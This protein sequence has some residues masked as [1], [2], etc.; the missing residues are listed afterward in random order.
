[1]TQDSGEDTAKN[2]DRRA[3][4]LAIDAEVERQLRDHVRSAGALTNRAALLVTSALIFVSIPKEGDG[5]GCWYA[6][7]LICGVAAAILGVIAL[8]FR[9]KNQEV[10]LDSL[11]SQLVGETELEAIRALTG[12]KRTT[13]KQDRERVQTTTQLTLTGFAFLAVSLL[14]T[15][16]YLLT[17]S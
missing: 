13:L 5:S 9:P 17:G 6:S 4:L 7:A 3:V 10:K 14:C 2:D 15:A 8:F 1:M 12:S 16:I 11:E